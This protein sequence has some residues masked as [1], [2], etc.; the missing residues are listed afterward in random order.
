[1]SMS[2]DINLGAFSLHVIFVFLFAVESVLFDTE[3]AGYAE[4]N[5]GPR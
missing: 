4:E 3:E 5:K 2:R 1:M